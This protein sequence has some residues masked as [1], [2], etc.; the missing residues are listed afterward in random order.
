MTAACHAEGSFGHALDYIRGWIGISLPESKHRPLRE[1]LAGFDRGA[2]FRDISARLEADPEEQSRFLGI[3]TINETYFFREQRQFALITSR[4]LPALAALGRPLS[5]WS[6]ACATG[7]EALSLAALGRS[8]L[9]PDGFVVHAGDISPA[10]L[11]HCAGGRYGPNSFREDGRRFLPHLEPYIT[12]DGQDI[13][14]GEELRRMVRFARLNLAALSYPGIPDALDLVLLRN[15]LMYMSMET[16]LAILDR[17]AA[18]V[19]E[20]GLIFLSS[21]DMPHLSHPSLALEETDGVFFF[22]KKGEGE[23]RRAAVPA[24]PHRKPADTPAAGRPTAGRPEPVPARLAADLATMRLDNPLFDGH[25]LPASD[26]GIQYLEAARRLGTGGDAMTVVIQAEERWGVN[27][28]SR[29]LAGMALREDQGRALAAFRD[30]VRLDDG[31]WPARLKIAF[32]LESMRGR[33]RAEARAEFAACADGIETYLAAGRCEYEFILE[34]FSA[35]YFLE[36]CRGWT[37]KLDAEG[38]GHGPR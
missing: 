18:K 6:A 31:F 5:F 11:A 23:T 30:A 1:Y 38:A 10:A 29:Y 13:V 21:S 8:V 7:E 17:V 33:A 19:A 20:G 9:G 4:I 25:D 34:G 35:R 3:V 26:A 14:V 16:R 12:R 32:H 24:A 36:L 15:V 22:R 27:A 2:T 37:R 28:L